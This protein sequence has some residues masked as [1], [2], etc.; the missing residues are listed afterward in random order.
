MMEGMGEKKRTEIVRGFIGELKKTLLEKMGTDLVS[1][2]LYGS[3]ARGRAEYGSDVD[4][5]IIAKNLS[6]SPIE[7]QVFFNR[8]LMEIEAPLREKLR[9][10]GWF[11]YI[12]AILKTPEEADRVSRIYFDMVEEAKIFYDKGDFFKALLDRIK[13]RLQ[14]LGAKKIQVGKMWY[15]DLKPDYK[16]GDVFEI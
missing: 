9:S 3:Y 2:V 13:K 16:P 11:P 10:T 14:E 12:S 4:I 6:S 8:I 7:R 1:I 5:L 15:W